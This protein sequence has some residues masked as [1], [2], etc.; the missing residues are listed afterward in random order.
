MATARMRVIEDEDGSTLRIVNGGGCLVIF[1]LP[2]F[3]SGLFIVQIPFGLIPVEVAGGPLLFSLM[4]PVGLAFAI[5]GAALMLG[6]NGIT[7]DRRFQTVIRWWGL[8]VP[9]RKTE[10]RFDR[11]DRVRMDQSKG[12]S[13]SQ[14]TYPV[15]LAGSLLE[16]RLIVSQGGNYQEA[17][18]LAETLS[19][20]MAKPLEDTSTGKRV[21]RDAASLDKPLAANIKESGILPDFPPVPVAMLTKVDD[22]TEGLYLSIPAPDP[23]P[24][25]Y[26]PLGVA[27]LVASIVGIG[28][29]PRLFE[30]GE[31]AYVR[32][33]LITFVGLFFVAGPL[34][35]ATRRVSR[36]SC[37]VTEVWLSNGLMRVEER[38]G[39]KAVR[40]GETEIPLDE[41]EE[42]E[43]PAQEEM[44]DTSGRVGTDRRGGLLSGGVIRLPDG[45]P[46]PRF[47]QFLLK[48]AK[49]PGLTARSDKVS[50]TFGRG[51][52]QD[53]L[54]YL[55]ALILRR[56]G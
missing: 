20:F 32:Y 14:D 44:L 47:L 39:R 43:L 6:R 2:F 30:I 9:L 49:A 29:I 15:C 52:S 31:P 5:A 38:S 17:R 19:R 51:L 27:M 50:V 1:G 42:L 4:L 41:L 45:R 24:F 10:Y 55:K 46:A 25:K 12:D 33:L 36:A 8:I 22:R 34:L 54:A 35:S 21:I 37:K 11:F 28:F 18:R 13:D 48:F 16:D 40:T 7:I 53:E 56:I 23:G 26:I 3:L